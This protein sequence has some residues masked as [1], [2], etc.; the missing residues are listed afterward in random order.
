MQKMT[1]AQAKKVIGGQDYNCTAAYNYIQVGTQTGCYETTSC[2]DKHGV[3]TTTNKP[4]DAAF[5][6]GLSNIKQ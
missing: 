6:K 5:C 1:E 3:L 2:R 4:V